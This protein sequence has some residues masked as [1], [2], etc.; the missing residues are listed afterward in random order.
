MSRKVL[1][2]EIRETMISAVLLESSFKGSVLVGQAAAPI[3]PDAPDDSPE[4]GLQA[5]LASVVEMLKPAGAACVLGIPTRSVSFRNLSVP[6]HDKKK[7]RQILPFELEPTL[8]RPVDELRFEFEAVRRDGHQ[9]LLALCV[10]GET[11]ETYIGLLESVNLRPV[12]ITPS[13]YA[14]ARVMVAATTENDDFLFIDTDT[15][16]HAVYM[17]SDGQVRLV[18]ALP[19]VGAGRSVARHL[20]ETLER[21]LIAANDSI[22]LVFD[23]KAL[24]AAGPE[25]PLLEPAGDRPSI[26]GLSVGTMDAVRHHTRL[27]GDTGTSDWQSGRFDTALAL[28][29]FETEAMGGVNFSTERSTVQH[30]W[31]EYRAQIILS[32]VLILL[33]LAVIL[34][35][36]LL[37]VSTKE[38]RVADLDRQIA[39]VFKETFPDATRVQAP[40]QQMQIKLREAGEA[41]M[42][43]ELPGAKVRVIDILNSLSQRI[44]DTVDVTVSRMVVGT[45]NVVLSG[46]TD[47]FNTVDDVKGRMEGDDIFKAVTI[48][49]A[50]MEKSGNRVRFKLK[51]DF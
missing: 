46:T 5:A 30:Y 13:A 27:T 39:A 38:R 51:L 40:L 15:A 8:P 45:D 43:P 20:E 28:A 23:P 47:N 3:E 34:G 21:T 25:S 1:G 29:L 11:I 10:A 17:I 22:G 50:D 4:T 7:I 33:T 42:G 2:L 44:P 31:S 48:T 16:T 35:T 32:G 12:V 24:I 41:G 6:F 26:M 36:Q 9:D 14:A 49:S 18:R 19:V 37:S